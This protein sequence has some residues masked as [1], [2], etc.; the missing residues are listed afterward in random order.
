MSPTYQT[1]SYLLISEFDRA[2]KRGD[3]VVYKYPKDT[4]EEFIQ[5]IV[6]LPGETVTIEQGV[7]SVNGQP[8]QE[9]YLA[10]STPYT[11]RV[12]VVLGSD[13][14]FMLGDNRSASNDS[15]YFG[16]VPVSDIVGKTF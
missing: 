3:I 13:E 2:Y 6:G 1:G 10:T 7:V 8:L 11:D 4:S 15:R 9:P 12:R 5:R 16:G 14:Y